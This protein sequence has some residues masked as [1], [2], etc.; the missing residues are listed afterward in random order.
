MISTL[1][2]LVF[3]LI[4]TV[5]AA[6]PCPFVGIACDTT[7]NFS[8]FIV[9]IAFIL[10]EIVS[11][12]SVLFV[13]I[14]GAHMLMNFGDESIISKGKKSVFYALGGFALALSSQAIVSFVVVHSMTI[15]AIDPHI[16]IMKAIVSAMLFIFN[17][18]FALM[19]LF[20]GFKLVLARGQ[21]S[22]LDSVKKGLTWT[23][24]GALAINL[25]YAL[26]EATVNLGF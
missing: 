16:E 24:F 19:M 23:V 2:S 5:A 7:S 26:V 8:I 6:P 20:Y 21:Q 18:V 11:G 10:V 25:S 1:S 9:N 13:V 4:P 12:L 15:S 17:G 3:W 14:G 22:E